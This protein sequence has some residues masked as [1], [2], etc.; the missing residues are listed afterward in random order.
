MAARASSARSPS[1]VNGSSSNAWRGPRP[2]CLFSDPSPGGCHHHHHH[3]LSPPR[4][5]ASAARPRAPRPAPPPVRG[6]AWWRW[7]GGRRPVRW[8]RSLWRRRRGPSACGR[9]RERRKV[10]E[11]KRRGGRV[12]KRALLPLFSLSPVLLPTSVPASTRRAVPR[13][14]APAAVAA[15]QSPSFEAGRSGGGMREEKGTRKKRGLMALQPTGRQKAHTSF[16]FFFRRPSAARPRA[17]SQTHTPTATPT[18]PPAHCHHVPRRRLCAVHV[19][20]HRRGRGVPARP[21]P[22]AWPVGSPP[23]QPVPPRPGPAPAR[24]AGRAQQA[25]VVLTRPVLVGRAP[26]GWCGRQGQGAGGG[27]GSR[28]GR[29]GRPQ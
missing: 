25:A 2:P 24:P 27:G 19:R 3:P 1:M 13:R 17:A 26:A 20:P 11:G 5:P 18:H 21:H 22:P 29:G 16:F 6:L 12:E 9:E 28:C 23:S 7:P 8:R 14:A 10:G 15:A 4:R